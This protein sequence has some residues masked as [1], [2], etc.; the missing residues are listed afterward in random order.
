MGKLLENKTGRSKPR[1]ARIMAIVRKMPKMPA[2]KSRRLT[3]LI[4][5]GKRARLTKKE[6]REVRALLDQMDRQSYWNLAQAI[7][8]EARMAESP[9]VRKRDDAWGNREFHRNCEGG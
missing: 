6:D 8:I 5:K 7:E 1:A 2:A 3:A 4:E 9:K